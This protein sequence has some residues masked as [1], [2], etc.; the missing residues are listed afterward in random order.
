MRS[1]STDVE[2]SV[3]VV[4]PGP[5]GPSELAGLAGGGEDAGRQVVDPMSTKGLE[6]DATVV[7]DPDEITRESPG[8]VRVLYV[9]LTRAAHRMTVVRP[10]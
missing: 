4:T 6:Y 1:C 5:A 2:G 10:G 7:V 8:G 3:A 9:A